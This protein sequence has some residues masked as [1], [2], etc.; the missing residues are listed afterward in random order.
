MIIVSGKV[1]IEDAGAIERLKPAMEAQIA[2]TKEEEG[3]IEYSYAVDVLSPTTI[4]VLEYWQ[5]WEAL[6]A[7]FQMPH[8]EAWRAALM[9]AGIVSRELQ[10]AET[11]LVREV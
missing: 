11:A 5:S 7:H 3:C 9:D 10:A 6:E 2:A 4:R 1:E 8:M